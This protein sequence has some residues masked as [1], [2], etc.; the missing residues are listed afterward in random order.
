MALIYTYPRLTTV[1]NDDLFLITDVDG[2]NTSV[3]PT[4]SVT[5]A[6]I[7]QTIVGSVTVDYIPV[8]DGSAFVDSVMFQEPGSA[9][10][11]TKN[12][13]IGGN[14]YQSDM[15]ESVSIG[16][17][18]LISGT[19]GTTGENVA[20][21]GDALAALTTGT[22]NI[23]IGRD[24]LRNIQT[25]RNNIAI[26]K[27]SQF[28]STTGI[29]NISLGFNSL[30]QSNVGERNVVIGHTATQNTTST[31]DIT[32][33]VILGAGALANGVTAAG[34]INNNVVIGESACQ[35]VSTTN[36][37]SSVMIG[38]RAGKS[39]IGNLNGDVGIGFNAFFGNAGGFSSGGGNIAIGAGA[40]GNNALVGVEKSIK[41]GGDAGRA[42]SNAVNIGAVSVAIGQANDALGSHS[43]LIGGYNN[44][45][46]SQAGF[47]GAGHDNTVSANATGG[48]I[49]G[50]Y[51]NTINGTGSAG[52]ALGSDLIVDGNNQVVVGRYN[53]SN[54][55]TKFVVGCGAS[56]AARQ[57]GFEVLNTGQLRATFY[58][59]SNFPAPGNYKFLV[60][61]STGNI[62]QVDDSA[63]QESELDVTNI[64]RDIGTS[65][66]T[67]PTPPLNIKI[68]RLAGGAGT[69]EV[70]INSSFPT[71]RLI[72]FISDGSFAANEG[73]LIRAAGGENINGQA[74]KTVLGPYKTV[75]LWFDGSEYFVLY[76]N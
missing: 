3:K 45:V 42:G 60:A 6:T 4:K 39:L 13:V 14:I 36:L 66:F 19:P 35:D 17:G 56:N 75:Q 38:Y 41:I 53:E 48:A 10:G 76:E 68:T 20:I 49:L 22:N 43:A 50:G 34:E 18:A 37:I 72:K 46:S 59:G 15:G 67:G 25:A 55:N 63:I 2:S 64:S 21:G 33:N 28:G 29:S 1:A 30:S 54:N 24:T 65:Y 52:M 74:N 31:F 70:V 8:S 61:G 23:A 5:L 16:K 71:N 62:L 58:G 47:I 11:T 9:Y 40:Q 44:S 51:D 12:V 57:N 26:G 69:I 73:L 7:K 27:N 32:G